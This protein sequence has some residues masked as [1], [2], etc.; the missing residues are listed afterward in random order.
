VFRVCNTT[1]ME[2]NSVAKLLFKKYGKKWY[3]ITPDY[4]FGH[5]LQKGFEAT[6]RSSAAPSLGNELTPLGTTDFSAYLIK[7]QRPTRT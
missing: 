1:Q 4:A 5:T 3:F 7:A 6:S 2:A